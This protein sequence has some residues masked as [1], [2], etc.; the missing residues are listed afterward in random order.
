[1]VNA[2]THVPDRMGWK[3][4][5]KIYRRHALRGGKGEMVVV[6]AHRAK[7]ND[8]RMVNPVRSKIK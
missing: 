3:V 4:P 5:Q 7:G 2:G 8:G 1:M 6:R